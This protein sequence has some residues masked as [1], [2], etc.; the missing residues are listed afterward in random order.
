M[1]SKATSL[2][3]LIL[4]RVDGGV[5]DYW[6]IYKL[7]YFIDFD[8]YS[9][10]RKSVTGYNYYNWQYGPMPYK[11]NSEYS[12]NSSNLISIGERDG[13][14]KK[15]DDK[16]VQIV[17]FTDPVDGFDLQEQLAIDSILD[18][19]SKLSGRELVTL[20]HADIPYQMTERGELIDYDYVSW[21]ES[22]VEVTDIS[23]QILT[24]ENYESNNQ[25]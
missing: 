13:I 21:R 1:P 24:N 3:K 4:T 16:Q 22:I 9:K 20:S 11:N 23:D 12:L 14:W 8:C 18:K 17:D 6:K 10:F 25:S 2:I 15:I 7:L 5:A 19:Y